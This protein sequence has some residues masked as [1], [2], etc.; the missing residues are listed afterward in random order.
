MSHVIVG[1]CVVMLKFYDQMN[2]TT[3]FAILCNML[4]NLV[5][6]GEIKHLMNIA[7]NELCMYHWWTIKFIKWQFLMNSFKLV[8]KSSSCIEF[9]N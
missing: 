6:E 1:M 5:L 9:A 3:F 7:N 4:C 2:D 8:C